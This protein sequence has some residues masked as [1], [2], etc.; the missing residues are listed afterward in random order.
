[1]D[2]T[3]GF[4]ILLGLMVG[5]GVGGLFVYL[6]LHSKEA[7]SLIKQFQYDDQGRLIQVMKEYNV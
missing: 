4:Y 1:M 2:E 7:K 5:I 3:K 6:L